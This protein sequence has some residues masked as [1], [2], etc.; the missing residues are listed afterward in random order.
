MGAALL[1]LA[2]LFA[3]ALLMVPTAVVLLQV[4]AAFLPYRA[5]R[6]TGPRP[7]IGVLIPAHNE[8]SR[9]VRTI[10]EAKFQ[11]APG[12]RLIVVAD[13]CDDRTASRARQA[14]A[15]V[16]VRTDATKRGKGYALEAGVASLGKRPPEVVIV[17]DADCTPVAGCFETLARVCV[18]WDRPMQASY[19]M[20]G[21]GDSGHARLAE[22]AWRVRVQLRP[23]GY[24]CLGLP[25]FPMGSGMAFP[26]GMIAGL[27]IGTDHITE[28]LLLGVVLALRGTPCRFCPSAMIV[29]SF[30]ASEVGRDTQRR[31]WVH[32]YF[33]I[34]VRH[35]VEL[36]AA[37]ARQRSLSTLALALDLAVPP[38]ALLLTIDMVAV[39]IGAAAYL[40]SGRP[41]ALY[42]SAG[43]LL[44]ALAFSLLAWVQ[45]GRDLIGWRE[46][47]AFPCHVGKIA[48]MA[49]DFAAGKRSSW[50][51]SER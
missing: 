24:A 29:S 38:L 2:Y 15:E 16:V 6:R 13:N 49:L 21:R 48:V 35:A 7:R 39:M 10:G 30:P 1:Q 34:L 18:G 9:I 41:S 5:L 4:S 27:P 12:D 19:A 42:G 32:G 46:L 17:L 43:L 28:D 14:G 47:A 25:C 3:V 11:L 51:R 20:L 44:V 26:W 33:S 50:G 37:A 22:F 31:R 8:E 40:V 36:F 45:C 23:A